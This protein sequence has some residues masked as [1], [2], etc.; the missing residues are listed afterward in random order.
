MAAA[1]VA[2][3][4]GA[5]VTI[6]EKNDRL[7]KKILVTGNGRCNLT[8]KNINAEQ[9]FF[10]YHNQEFA[11]PTLTRFPYA[12]IERFFFDLGLITISN[13]QGWVFPH[14]RWANS[15]LDVLVAAVQR[16]DIEVLTS[17]EVTN[18][19]Q[20]EPGTYRI[21][22]SE[23]DTLQAPT[24]VIANGNSNI[25]HSL[26]RLKSN[27]QQPILGPLSTELEPIKGLDGIK[28]SAS[29]DL[30]RNKQTI[31]S[32]SGEIL[33]RSY[34]ISGIAVF[35]LSRHAQVGDTLSV[36]LMPEYQLEEL[37]AL[38]KE[39]AGKLGRVTMQEMLVGLVHQ[40]LSLAV[41]KAIGSK[42]SEPFDENVIPQLA[43]QLKAFKLRITR[44]PKQQ[45]AQVIRG[46]FAPECFN[47]QTLESLVYPG[48]FAA[49]EALDV[50]GP[51][52]G[53]NLHWAWASG[54]VA[55]EQA[56][57]SVNR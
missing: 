44:M 55:G 35:N 23:G 41:I 34:G 26:S 2:A 9:G 38:L 57:S 4:A 54:C 42:A 14:S 56:A 28:C 43:E 8:N 7:G 22:C 19:E 12:E 25:A 30:I 20:K 15:V 40:R 27:A 47:A 33:F 18:I 6:A 21:T 39:R 53:Y 17:T 24:L 45:Q 10:E 50:D 46:G 52:G 48:L 11:T 32:E 3:K 16:L 31:Q 37:G 29:L 49:G 5:Q 1:I 51:C 13:E 36:D